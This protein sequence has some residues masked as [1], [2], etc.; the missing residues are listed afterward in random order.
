[1][2]PIIYVETNFLLSFATGRDQATAD[3]IASPP[4]GVEFAIPSVCIM[5]AF[6]TFERM[7]KQHKRFLE[8]FQNK[9][10]ECDREIVREDRAHRAEQLRSSNRADLRWMPLR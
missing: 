8:E 4:D 3:L 1:M 2:T 7:R 5:E 9:V 6:S 10:Q